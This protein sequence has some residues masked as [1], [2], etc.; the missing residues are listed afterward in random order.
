MLRYMLVIGSAILVACVVF[1]QDAPLE[2]DAPMQPP[3]DQ[4]DSLPETAVHEIFESLPAGAA[5]RIVR[6][7]KT[8]RVLE[9]ETIRSAH[10]VAGDALLE[11]TVLG[12][13][14][15]VNGS[16][17]LG[18]Q[19]SIEGDLILVMADGVYDP[20]QVGG[21][22]RQ[23]RSGA[24]MSG[25]LSLL[26]G[27]PRRE[28]EPSS[29]T[30]HVLTGYRVSWGNVWLL[31]KIATFGLVLVVHLFFVGILPTN[32]ESMTHGFATRPLGSAFLGI[33]V[34]LIL[35]PVVLLCLFSPLGILILLSVAMV[36]VSLAVFGKTAILLA[37]GNAILQRRHANSSAIF[38]GYVIYSLATSLPFLGLPIF[39]IINFLSVGLCIRSHLGVSPAK[40]Q[41]TRRQTSREV[42]KGWDSPVRGS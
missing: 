11:G 5:A 37:L 36:L 38:V 39:L 12:N 16:V 33:G 13:L 29:Q 14:T 21:E 22:V 27:P 24:L 35:I 19:A 42:R 20:S 9:A 32:I 23:I 8:L 10:V 2:G 26:T 17:S 25:L 4:E 3:S 7:G 28:S 41:G 6:V 31:W 34:V 40:V 18:A 1:A 30:I 15:V